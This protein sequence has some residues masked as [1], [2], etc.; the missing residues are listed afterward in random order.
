VAS[1]EAPFYIMKQDSHIRKSRQS[2]GKRGSEFVGIWLVQQSHSK[3][4][5]VLVRGYILQDKVIRN[6]IKNR[7]TKKFLLWTS[8]RI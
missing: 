1:R 5:V 8:T 3:V 4:G 2:R 7:V 6:S